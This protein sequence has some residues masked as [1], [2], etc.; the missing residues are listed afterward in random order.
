MCM[1]SNV[2]FVAC[3]A[4]VGLQERRPG[5]SEGEQQELLR[6][7]EEGSSCGQ[8]QGAGGVLCCHKEEC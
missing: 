2:A 5:R 7:G 8:A 3:V 1:H 4:V 6:T